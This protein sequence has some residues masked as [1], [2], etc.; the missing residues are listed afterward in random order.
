MHSEALCTQA[1]EWGCKQSGD[2]QEGPTGTGEVGPAPERKAFTLTRGC[3]GQG[4][5]SCY[6]P[7]PAIRA[8]LLAEISVSAVRGALFHSTAGFLCSRSHKRPVHPVNLLSC[9]H[10]SLRQ[11]QS[12]RLSTCKD[13]VPVSLP[14][15][16]G[17]RP[18]AVFVRSVALSWVKEKHGIEEMGMGTGRQQQLQG[19]S[20]GYST[21]SD[22]AAE[23]QSIPL[24]PRAT[25]RKYS[26][27]GVIIS[28]G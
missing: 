13:Q 23:M 1:G 28:K 27:E 9:L 7:C 4:A 22:S 15:Y 8:L 25:V 16:K 26:Q 11:Q 17:Q 19:K 5:F 2:T 12:N 14:G 21:A 3:Q 20:S 18:L 6:F 10:L 24:C